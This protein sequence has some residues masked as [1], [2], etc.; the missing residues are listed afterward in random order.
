MT[1]LS[2]TLLYPTIAMHARR[3]SSDIVFGVWASIVLTGLALISVALGIAPVVDP[4]L[5]PAL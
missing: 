2:P 5:F 1:L 3:S 4:T